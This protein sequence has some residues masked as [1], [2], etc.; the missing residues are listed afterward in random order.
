M[1]LVAP[2]SAFDTADHLKRTDKDS[3]SDALKHI[4][5]DIE[6]ICL[7]GQSIGAE[8]NKTQVICQPPPIMPPCHAE[9]VPPDR[10]EITAAGL[11]LNIANH[12]LK[13]DLDE[14]QPY[15]RAGGK[16]F[17]QDFKILY[18]QAKNLDTEIVNLNNL[19]ILQA[20]ELPYDEPKVLSETNQIGTIVKDAEN[21]CKQLEND[22]RPMTHA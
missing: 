18:D 15:A 14:L 3:I 8:M 16:K 20:H 22:L 13:N 7:G 2:E 11:D 9:E 17:E 1:K 19:T 6:V 5:D 21:T 10:S 4:Y 12:M